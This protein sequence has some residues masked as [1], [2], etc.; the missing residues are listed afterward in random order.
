MSRFKTDFVQYKTAKVIFQ[1]CGPEIQ[2]D[3]QSNRYSVN[4][5]HIGRSL[6]AALPSQ[7]KQDDSPLALFLLPEY[8]F[9]NNPRTTSELLLF[10]QDRFINNELD[11]LTQSY[12]TPA[13]GIKKPQKAIR[14]PFFA[15]KKFVSSNRTTSRSTIQLLIP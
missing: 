9:L 3:R 14:S 10:K 12:L 5:A 6:H 8:Y 11:H 4:G 15:V 2:Q 7:S 1:K 13:L